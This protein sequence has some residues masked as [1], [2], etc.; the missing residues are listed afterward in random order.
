[1]SSEPA[2]PPSPVL[3]DRELEVLR[4]VATGATNNQIGRALFISVNTVK[5][6]LNNIFTKLG[7]QSRTEAALYAVRHGWIVLERPD[8]PAAST[9]AAI[10]E[11]PASP[12]PAAPVAA[13]PT[14]TVVIAPPVGEV[15][16]PTGRGRV[17]ALA[18]VLVLGLVV[19]PLASSAQPW[20]EWLGAPAASSATAVVSPPP[21]WQRVAPLPAPRDAMAVATA[22]NLIYL[23]GGQEAGGVVNAV[24]V[25]DPAANQWSRKADKPTALQGNSAAMIGGRV[26][27][28]GGCDAQDQPSAVMEIY[29]P[30]SDS[31]QAG[32]PLPKALCHYALSTLEGRLYLFGG[33][34]GRS[35]VSD[36]LVFDPAR[37][38][39]SAH[40]PLPGPRADAA[41]AAIG[42]RIF[43]VGG[44]QSEGLLDEVLSFDPTQPANS[45]Q[46]WARKPPLR[47]PRAR[48]GL[49]VLAGNL[50]AMGGG[51][52]G[53]LR[54]NE[55][56]DSATSQ[57]SEF[58]SA[59][60]TLWRV[61]A[62][63]ALDTKIY[64]F[65]GWNSQP[66]DAVQ[67]YTALYRFFLPK[68][69]P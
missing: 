65:G 5:V 20:R 24:S 39:W 51:W 17:M 67:L 7:V 26:Y 42:E 69:G 66:N 52:S 16:R 22:D 63:A 40:A 30:A 46:V 50:Y 48:L 6:H 34:D 33:W 28:P 10:A 13:A 49:V 60:E 14:E 68:A 37:G 23:I 11:I 36:V 3:S 53:P 27:V 21:R 41:A 31:W 47:H 19:F 43:V 35:M 59:Q 62:A 9:T 18:F 57:W 56:Y 4:L 29:D 2:T 25:Y 54:E 32:A 45:A 15:E 44:R 8:A 38:E 61:G 1:M 55:R 64:L 12:A 58:E